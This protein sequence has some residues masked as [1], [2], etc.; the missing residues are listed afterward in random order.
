MHEW[1]AGM[2]WEDIYYRAIH[3]PF[4]PTME[5]IDLSNPMRDSVQDV[6][7]DYER[8]EPIRGKLHP[9]TEG[10]DENF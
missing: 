5:S 7:L 6:L 1:F 8:R 9:P 3:P 10:W 4:I 2:N